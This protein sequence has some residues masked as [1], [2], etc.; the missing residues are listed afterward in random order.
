MDESF[1]MIRRL[2]DFYFV[3]LLILLL[4]YNPIGYEPRSAIVYHKPTKVF[5]LVKK[6]L[7]VFTG[8]PRILRKFCTLA[9]RHVF[10]L[11]APTALASATEFLS[12]PL[13]S[14]AIRPGSRPPSSGCF[15]GNAGKLS[16][17]NSRSQRKR[18][19]Q[20]EP[21]LVSTVRIATRDM[22]M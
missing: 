2:E 7:S 4:A 19:M 22:G 20:T 18:D 14:R 16:P 21:G 10:L 13:P 6:P 1:I 11:G 8:T 3:L 12:Q 17:L 9:I 5:Q 15:P